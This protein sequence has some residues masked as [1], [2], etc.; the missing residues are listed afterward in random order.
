MIPPTPLPMPPTTDSVVTVI[1]VYSWPFLFSAVVGLIVWI[2]KERAMERAT[3]DFTGAVNRVRADFAQA[4]NTH[5]E[6]SRTDYDKAERRLD[7]LDAEVFGTDGE[8]GGL[9]VEMRRVKHGVRALLLMRLAGDGA[10]VAGD[11]QEILSE[12]E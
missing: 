12:L 1:A 6:L 11:V 7:R 3:N 4:M 9:K 5:R 8:K 10:D 2:W